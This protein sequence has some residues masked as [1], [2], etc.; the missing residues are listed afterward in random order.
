MVSVSDLRNKSFEF[1]SHRILNFSICLQLTQK[2]TDYPT[3]LIN[4][5]IQLRSYN[6]FKKKVEDRCISCSV[7]NSICNS[8]PMCIYNSGTVLDLSKKTLQFFTLD[9]W[10][11][12]Y[13]P[14][15]G[16]RCT[17]LAQSAY[18]KTTLGQFWNKVA[19]YPGFYWNCQGS[20][21]SISKG[22]FIKMM[23]PTR[24]YS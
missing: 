14:N 23:L 5:D 24:F 11:T 16:K 20:F 19:C 6:E 8:G 7:Q 1:E 22:T 18:Q 2:A 9:R 4:M 3:K 17:R 10:V 21:S 13:R 12:H 15:F